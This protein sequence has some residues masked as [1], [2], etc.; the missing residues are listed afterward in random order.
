MPYEKS[1]EQRAIDWGKIIETALTAPGNVGN[2]YS[3]FY[4]YSFLNQMFLRMQG[5]YEPVA[6]MKRWNAL[7]RTVLSGSKAKEIIVPI[8]ARKPKEDEDEEA[9]IIGF[10]AVRRIFTLSQTEGQELPP[11]QLPEWDVDTAL[12]KL[13]IRQVPFTALSG[14]VQGYS[15]GHDI[16]ISPIAVNPA[17]T[18]FHEIGHV[19]LGHT[20]PENVGQYA[21]HR[22][23]F[24]FQAEATA[25]LTMNEL[26]QLDEETATRSRGYVQSWLEGER[27][28][29]KAIREVF[30][31][32]DQI[33]KAGRLAVEEVIN[34]DDKTLGSET[35]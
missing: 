27:P 28:P 16:A 23:I 32:T 4:E 7:G 26:Q 6:T 8:F 29:D 9:A 18:R 33:L 34:R 30:S 25:Y 24:E 19:V 17:K 11:V 20:L 10:K 1:P 35:V 12:E 31:A 15:R 3:R 21:T 5:V 2:V 13:G 22:G 14:N